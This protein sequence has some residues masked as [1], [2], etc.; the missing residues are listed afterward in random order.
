MAVNSYLED[1]SLDAEQT[2]QESSQFL[3]P[4]PYAAKR[5]RIVDMC[6]SRSSYSHLRNTE[7][8]LKALTSTA[9]SEILSSSAAVSEAAM[10]MKRAEGGCRLRRDTDA[11]LPR[12][13]FLQS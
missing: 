1:E 9:S 11:T 6:L 8:G 12:G 5:N 3:A 7:F 10:A 4:T 2:R 13:A